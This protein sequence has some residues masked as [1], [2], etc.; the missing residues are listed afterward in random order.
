VF[1]ETMAGCYTSFPLARAARPIQTPAA[2]SHPL[3]S[4]WLAVPALAF[5]L[6]GCD[7]PA[8][9]ADLKAETPPSAQSTAQQPALAPQPAPGSTEAT[10]SLADQ[11]FGA[12]ITLTEDTQLANIAASPSEF[13]G[14]TVRTTGVV[15]AVCK[16]AGCWMEIGDDAS[17]AHIKMA[18]HAFVVPRRADG[19]TAIVEG[20]VKAGAPQN[21]C[22]SKDSCGGEDNG[23]VAKVEIVATGVQ[24]V[25]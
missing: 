14:K 16:K 13:A 17:R 25:D 20:T 5:A 11:K 24:F 19:H 2:M 4:P 21:E 1:I 7:A 3:R 23:A 6:S 12:P 18:N 15:K 8:V 10:V 22:G 9:A